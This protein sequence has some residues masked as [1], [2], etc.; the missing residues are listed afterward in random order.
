MWNFYWPGIEQDAEPVGKHAL[1]SV[2]HMQHQK[3]F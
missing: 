1:L 3:R 2:L